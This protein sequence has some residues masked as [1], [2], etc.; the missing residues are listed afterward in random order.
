MFEGASMDSETRQWLYSKT[1]L[2]LE[3]IYFDSTTTTWMRRLILKR[4]MIP[5][6][7]IEAGIHSEDEEIAVEAALHY[8]TPLE[9]LREAA[10][11]SPHHVVRECAAER[12][13]GTRLSQIE[14][15][16]SC[17]SESSSVC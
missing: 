1:P 5:V 2:E 4:T 13:M 12:L 15:Q 7:I 17:W 3:S 11:T 10:E 16:M 14:Q 9:K 6:T 8:W